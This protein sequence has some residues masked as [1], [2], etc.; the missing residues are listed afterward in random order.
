MNLDK[1][2]IELVHKY[3]D[4]E[5]LSEIAPHL[6]KRKNKVLDSYRNLLDEAADIL[7][8]YENRMKEWKTKLNK[9]KDLESSL[10]FDSLVDLGG[11][12]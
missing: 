4:V 10:I 2:R 9:V 5:F 12:H 8:D 11:N 3:E 6:S 7:S 1:D